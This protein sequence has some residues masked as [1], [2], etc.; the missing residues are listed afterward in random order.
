MVSNT[1][2]SIYINLFFATYELNIFPFFL[3]FTLHFFPP[4]SDE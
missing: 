3:L 2:K 4:N 1:E